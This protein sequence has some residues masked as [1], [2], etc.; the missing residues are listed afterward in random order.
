MEGSSVATYTF[1]K[2]DQVVTMDTKSIITIQDE[3]I[4]VDPQVLFL[5]LVMVGTKY[6]ELQDVFNHKLCHYRPGAVF[7]KLLN[8]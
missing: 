5:R 4:H 1:R 8:L 6:G 3:P 2:T 7:I